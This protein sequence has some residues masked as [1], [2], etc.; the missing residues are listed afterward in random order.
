MAR[1]PRITRVPTAGNG[2]SNL[3][4]GD[5]AGKRLCHRTAGMQRF[6]V[7]DRN[8]RE[9]RAMVIVCASNHRRA[10]LATECVVALAILVSTA[11]PLSVAFVQE[12][13]LCHAA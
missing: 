4:D 10:A 7:L 5:R 13:K 8:N 12:I 9:C 6:S 11:I 1:R 3:Y 2:L